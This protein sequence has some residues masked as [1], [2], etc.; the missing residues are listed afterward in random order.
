MKKINKF[1]KLKKK[2]K[3]KVSVLFEIFVVYTQGL[4]S[5]NFIFQAAFSCPDIIDQLHHKK[6]WLT[7]KCISTAQII[8][9]QCCLPSEQVRA[10]SHSLP[11]Q[12]GHSHPQ[13]GQQSSHLQRGLSRGF[14][15]VWWENRTLL[16][17]PEWTFCPS[18]ERW[19]AKTPG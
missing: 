12:P 7:W 1:Q 2:K 15:P 6:L 18:I 9:L 14:F 17:L 8:D 4:G 3:I 10:L 19:P 16:H 5:F 13:P 11:Y